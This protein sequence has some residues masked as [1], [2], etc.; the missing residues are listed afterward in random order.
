MT[1]LVDWCASR[2][3][4]VV[5]FVVISLGAGIAGYVG[6]PKEGAPNIDIP[7]LYVS[8]PL[9]GV[10]ATDAERLI[11][12]PLEQEL[13]GVDN[14]KDMTGIATRGHA[15]VLLEFD[16][17]WDKQAVLADVRDKV[18]QAEAQFPAAAEDSVIRE[19][20]LS[21]FPIL[22]VSLSG[23]VPERTL[24]RLADD[25]QREI[26]GIPAVLEAQLTGDREEMV[27]VL[28]DPLRLE[29]YGL[30][31]QELLNVV[32]RNNRLVAADE[33]RSGT[34]AFSVAVP[35]A[36]ETPRDRKSVV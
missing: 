21:Q 8:V 1:G 14:L 33:V 11:V 3:R 32:D 19:I 2:A 17:G 6:L 7:V 29:S 27:E 30:T 28:V 10:S 18:D 25:L 23:E 16:F 34:G 24:M 31:A 5:A 12:R 13:R 4:M 9:P 15:A 22:V 35:G 20:N 36:F 26:E